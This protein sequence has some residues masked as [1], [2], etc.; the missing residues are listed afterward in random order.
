MGVRFAFVPH[1]L[2]NIHKIRHQY[3]EAFDNS[4]ATDEFGRPAVV[5][6]IY[7]FHNLR[8]N[9]RCTYRESEIRSLLG[10]KQIIRVSLDARSIAQVAATRSREK[11]LTHEDLS[12]ANDRAA[13]KAYYVRAF[14]KS[15]VSKSTTSLRSFIAKISRDPEA[16]EFTWTPSAGTLRRALAEGEAGFRR[17]AF[18]QRKHLTLSAKRRG[19]FDEIIQRCIAWYW[20]DFYRSRDEAYARFQ[21]YLQLYRALLRGHNTTNEVACSLLSYSAFCRRIARSGCYETER[22]KYGER[23]A[24]AKFLGTTLSWTPTRILQYVLFDHTSVDTIC[25]LDTKS[26]LPL[27]RPT[28]VA[29]LDAFTRSVLGC[30]VTFEPPSLY[31]ISACFKQAV[32][33]KD[34]FLA[35][36]PHLKNSWDNHGKP[37][38]VVVDN[39]W[40]TVGKSFQDGVIDFG[41]DVIWAPI[42][43]PEYKIYVERF[44]ETLNLILFHRISGGI[45]YPPHTLRKLGFDPAKTAVLTLETLWELILEAIVDNYHITVHD[46]INMQPNLAWKIGARATGITVFAD[47]PDRLDAFFGM[48]VSDITVRR[49]G[50]RHFGLKYHDEDV[51]TQLLHDNAA[52]QVGRNP[53]RGSNQFKTKFT[54]NPADI[55]GMNV[56]SI[57]RQEY[58]RLKCTDEKYANGLPLAVHRQVRQ[59]ANERNNEYRTE[60]DRLAALNQLRAHAETHDPKLRMRSRRKELQLRNGALSTPYKGGVPLLTVPASTSGMGAYFIATDVMAGDRQDGG[61]PLRQSRRGGKAATEKAAGTRAAN[62]EKERRIGEIT[63]PPTGD[64]SSPVARLDKVSKDV[65]DMFSSEDPASIRSSWTNEK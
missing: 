57:A 50:V 61:K 64:Q 31:T 30:F 29:A 20:S 18:Y 32:L 36:V 51:V 49:S 52:Y 19:R 56:W 35:T 39:A 8:Q 21:R 9:V 60:K 55:G 37:Q 11:K 63:P 14:D 26:L 25:V 62:Q 27:G 47:D 54:I 12:E 13:I 40:E 43:T 17:K 42:K 53:A 65:V 28:F 10:Q 6:D 1:A 3:L 15:P 34:D 2:Y 45:P 7:V 58:V 33:P 16:Q 23:A 22:V 4:H 44:F 41:V 5:E 38:Y 48:T 46:G 59:Y 24:R